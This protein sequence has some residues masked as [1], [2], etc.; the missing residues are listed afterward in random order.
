VF[1]FAHLENFPTTSGFLRAAN[2][3]KGG[4]RF[5][6]EMVNLVEIFHVMKIIGISLWVLSKNSNQT[7]N[8]TTLMIGPEV[9]Q[10]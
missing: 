9:D 1:N 2:R 10:K 6:F 7:K 8:K 4:F 5:F 3:K